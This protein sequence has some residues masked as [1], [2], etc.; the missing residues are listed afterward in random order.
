MFEEMID[1]YIKK[2]QEQQFLELFSLLNRLF[3]IGIIF[4]IRNRSDGGE[5]WFQNLYIFQRK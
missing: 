3:K 1:K 2:V 5:I 4:I